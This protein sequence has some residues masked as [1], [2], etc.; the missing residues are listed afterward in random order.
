MSESVNIKESEWGYGYLSREIISRSTQSLDVKR[1]VIILAVIWT[2]LIVGFGVWNGKRN[3][4]ERRELIRNEARAHFLKDQAFRFW[5]AGHGGVYVPSTEHTPPNPYLSHIP[6]RDIET[7]EGKKL[8]LMNGAYMLRQTMENFDEMYGIKGHITSIKPLRPENGPDEWERTALEAFERGEAEVDEFTEINGEPYLRLMRPM[9]VQER[10]LKCHEHQGYKVGDIR[11]G[12]GISVPASTVFSQ[13]REEVVNHSIGLGL[14]WLIG[15]AGLALGFIHIQR[16]VR[17]RDWAID[18]LQEQ[19]NLLQTV[20]DTTPDPLALKNRDS[21]YQVVNRAFSEFLGKPPGEIIG[22]TETELFPDEEA[23]K[24][25]RDDTKVMESGIGQYKDEHV[26]DGTSESW[27]SVSKTPVKNLSGD[28][29]GILCSVRDITVRKQGEEEKLVLERMQHTQKLESLSVLAGGIAHDFNNILTII[30][31]NATLSFEQLPP[32]SPVYS[33]IQEIETAT[34]R[35]TELAKQ[36][37]TYSGKG[38]FAIEPINIEKLIKE[39]V[40]QLEVAI[41]KKTVLK[42]NFAKNLPTFDGDMAQISQIIMNLITNASE[43]IGSKGGIINL[44]TGI[45]HCDCT[46]LD[47]INEVLRT[48][49]IDPLS[50]G[51]YVYLEVVDTGCGMDVVTI[52]KIFDP[53]FT[54][55]FMGRGLGMSAVLGIVRGHDG[56]IKVHSEVGK[57]SKLKVLFPVARNNTYH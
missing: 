1:Y 37:L 46:Y 12:V 39:T 33:N 32:K 21:V 3:M 41:S 44:S 23:K 7:K 31:G 14:L 49:F 8:T 42:Y 53:F 55:K 24:H 47:S 25:L 56:A 17:E 2:T 10:C 28:V 57:G 16:R 45:M 9:V 18:T 50:E 26:I 22:K 52:E 15:L 13:A 34:K 4:Q 5:A 20:I 51:L 43:A 38:C 40:Q 27:L 11:G 36:M 19:T 35:A 6:D 30:L 54:T 29:M 48:I